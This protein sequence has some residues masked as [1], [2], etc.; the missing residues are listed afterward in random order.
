MTPW[1]KTT[2]CL[3][4]LRI[5]KKNCE[6]LLAYQ[7]KN[8]R[9]NKLFN[10]WCNEFQHQNILSDFRNMSIWS[11]ETTS[12]LWLCFDKTWKITSKTN[13]YVEKKI[14]FQWT[15]LSK[16]RLNLTTNY[17]NRRWTNDIWIN[18]LD[19]LKIISNFEFIKKQKNYHDVKNTNN[20]SQFL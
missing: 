1:K 7:T 8:K 10:I 6:R 20:S 4:F 16:R 19:K 5:S 9:Q 17:I 15:I 14:F 18:S 12:H 11:N 3:I 13:W 2:M